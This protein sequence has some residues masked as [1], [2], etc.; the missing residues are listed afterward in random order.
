[1]SADP[2][3][4][5]SSTIVLA[6]AGEADRAAVLSAVALGNTARDTLVHLPIAAYEDMARKGGLLLVRDGAEEIIGY[7]LYALTRSH[8]R[9]IHLCVRRDYRGQGIARQLVAQISLQHQGY[10]GIKARCR[11]SYGLG[12]VWSKLGFSQTS[13][14]A[15]RSRDG[16]ILVI[17]WHDHEHPNLLSR[18]SEQVLVRAA[19]DLNVVRA[20]AGPQRGRACR[21]PLPRKVD[22]EEQPVRTHRSFTNHRDI[23]GYPRDQV[24]GHGA[25]RRQ[26]AHRLI[27]RGTRA[28][29]A[30]VG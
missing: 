27:R 19:V 6:P 25:G 21:R 10:P 14:K 18:L 3:E 5:A 15:S 13:E 9:L 24:R 30:A 2:Q 22:G 29:R 20:L 17:W 11:H 7:A 8:I 16:Q 26:L 28:S 12:D 4:P 23:Y 1:M